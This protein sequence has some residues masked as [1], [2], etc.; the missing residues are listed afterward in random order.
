M[1]RKG[2]ILA[3]GTGTRLYPI[4]LSISKHLL[5]VYDKPMVYY[6]LS[7]LMLANIRDI[8][9]ISTPQ[10]LPLYKRLLGSGNQWGINF[11]YAEQ[12][13]PD[14]IAQALLIG[15]DFINGQSC[16]LVL[17]DN[18]IYG[19]SLVEQLRIANQREEGGTIFVYRVKNPGEYGVA[20]LDE[21]NRPLNLV[22]K[23]KQ[24]I[25]NWAITGLYFYDS[26]VTDIVRQLEPSTR[27]ELEITDV[28][29]AYLEMDALHVNTLGRGIAWLDGGTPE[30]LLQA[31][32]FVETMQQRQ[33]LKIAC[34]E[35]IAYRQG[36]INISQFEQIAKSLEKSSYGK[37]LLELIE[38]KEIELA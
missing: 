38:N 2:I 9:V 26:R 13:K 19:Q 14:G 30:S 23:P 25:S 37:Y 3:G 10:D 33:G 34:P 36:F 1:T 15:E 7:V 17:G 6:P 31:N 29:L 16:A 4:S 32:L 24:H 18:I 27:G 8:L 21:A 5:P 22:E 35:E 20:V 11:S 28:N 12:S